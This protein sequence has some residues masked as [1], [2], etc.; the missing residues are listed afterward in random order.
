MNVLKNIFTAALAVATVACLPVLAHAA[1]A[2]CAGGNCCAKGI[3]CTMPGCCKTDKSCCN[4]TTGIC[5]ST[6]GCLT[7]NCCATAKKANCH[8][9]VATTGKSKSHAAAAHPSTAK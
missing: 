6:C 8:T 5:A 4:P 2:C 3:C 1:P 7:M 9:K